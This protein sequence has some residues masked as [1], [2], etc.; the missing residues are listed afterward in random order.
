MTTNQS[1]RKNVLRLMTAQ[2]VSTQN[3]AKAIGLAPYTCEIMLKSDVEID[4]HLLNKIANKLHTDPDDLLIEQA[5]EQ[6]SAYDIMTE[7]IAAW[8]ARHG[9][10]APELAKRSGLTPQGIYLIEKH[11]TNP[12]LSSIV[13]IA[14]TMNVSVAQLF[15]PASEQ[16]VEKTEPK[17][18]R[19][20]VLY[21]T[22]Y[23][24]VLAA[25]KEAK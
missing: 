12:S 24:A 8:R 2:G 14:A 7:N 21:D 13:K 3:L 20:S 23:T 4:Q 10:S 16:K 5:E 6:K 22:I 25:L 1:F 15:T 18:E 19:K 9:I 11:Q 17:T